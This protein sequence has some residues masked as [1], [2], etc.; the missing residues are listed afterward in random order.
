[1]K[2]ILLLTVAMCC[3]N[4]QAQCDEIDDHLTQFLKGTNVV[5]RTL[6]EQ[7]EVVS[8]VDPA[9]QPTVRILG[10]KD[11]QFEP[12]PQLKAILPG[13]LGAAPQ[14]TLCAAGTIEMRLP[15]RTSILAQGGLANFKGVIPRPQISGGAHNPPGYS[16]HAIFQTIVDASA[17]QTTMTQYRTT[18]FPA[19]QFQLGQ[20]WVIGYH[21]NGT[22]DESIESGI[23]QAPLFYSNST[24]TH[25]FI[26]IALPSIVCKNTGCAAFV[27]TSSALPIGGSIRWSIVGTTTNEH[28]HAWYHDP[29]TG[30]WVLF[31]L[32]M[33]HLR[34]HTRSLVTTPPLFLVP[35][36]Q[37]ANRIDYGGEVWVTGDVPPIANPTV[38]MG[39]GYHP[40]TTNTPFE[41][42]VAYHRNL[43]YADL[44]GVLHDLVPTWLPPPPATIG[45]TPIDNSDPAYPYACAYGAK[46]YSAA[47]PYKPGWGSTVFFG[48][49]GVGGNPPC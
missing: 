18:P 47:A 4:F 5:M 43:I 36:S 45:G 21:T 40:S 22:P 49:D 13:R 48:G 32:A 46:W 34:I 6:D 7:G 37:H 42:Y 8:C 25:F 2:K 27:Q 14:S 33:S 17:A 15:S 1:M 26:F 28:S 44:G 23:E 19:T 24:E 20:I 11:I 9:T 10:I 35:L 29:G 3:A 38:P 31:S 39:A 16:Y 12:S 41:K 30:N